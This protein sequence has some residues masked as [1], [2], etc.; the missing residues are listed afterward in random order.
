M[1]SGFGVRFIKIFI[2]LFA[3]TSF[4]GCTALIEKGSSHTPEHYNQCLVG[5]AVT[6]AVIGAVVATPLAAGIGTIVGSA[7]GVHICGEE[8]VTGTDRM[9]PEQSGYFW[10]DD[11]DAD[12][13]L[14][15]SDACPST[16]MGVEID[17]NGCASDSDGDGVPDYLDQCLETLSGDIVDTT[18]C[19]LPLVTLQALIGFELESAVLKPEGKLILDGIL[20][21]LRDRA[22]QEISIEGHTDSTGSDAYN[23]DLSQRRAESVV[24]YLVLKG[25][26]RSRL[27]AVGVGES[28]PATSNDSLE[29]RIYN[30]RVEI[31]AR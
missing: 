22:N 19:N 9:E 2:V 25:I 6:G 23:I 5:T 14:D 10:P 3:G 4:A 13:V 8:T 29:G 12:G 20:S 26:D 31:Y 27:N 1:R 16:P 28:S 11:Q 7:V 15:G 21:D 17:N 24:N 30:R 18:G